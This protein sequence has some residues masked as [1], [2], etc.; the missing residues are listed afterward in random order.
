MNLIHIVD[1]LNDEEYIYSNG[2]TISLQQAAIS[3]VDK[4]KDTKWSLLQN[5]EYNICEDKCEIFINEQVIERGWVWNSKNMTK[6]I[7]Y[8]LSYI[9]LFS[10]EEK[11]KQIEQSVQTEEIVDNYVDYSADYS[12]YIN[13]TDYVDYINYD[14]YDNVVRQQT[15]NLYIKNT[16]VDI[17]NN[18]GFF[19][20][21][22]YKIDLGL[23]YSNNPFDPVNNLSSKTNIWSGPN[24][25]Y[26]I[27]Y[28]VPLDDTLLMEDPQQRIISDLNIE[29][30][31]R[32]ALP[33][34][35]LRRFKQD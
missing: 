5:V 2:L 3:L 26:A 15:E 14:H 23:G 30:K 35:G 18:S 16:N 25:K 31:R 20:V 13:Y 19:N 29:I 33:N 21:G 34:F 9:S 12:D 8:K 32:L 4:L 10:V 7:L 17:Y 24:H 22:D 11:P 27:N 1:N 6:K 28:T